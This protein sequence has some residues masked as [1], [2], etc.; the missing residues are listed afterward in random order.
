MAHTTFVFF[1]PS[2]SV[3]VGDLSPEVNDEILRKTFQAFGTLSDARCMWD[4]TSGKS[5]GYGFLAFRDR[6][7]AEQAIATMNGEWLGSRAIRVNWA[8]QKNQQAGMPVA[9]GPGNANALG[10]GGGGGGGGPGAGGPGGPPPPPGMPQPPMGMPVPQSVPTEYATPGGTSYEIVVAQSSSTNTT[11]VDPL[12]TTIRNLHADSC[13]P[14]TH[15]AAS[16][17]A[18]SCR[19]ATRPTSFRSSKT[20]AT[21]LRFAC[22]P[23]A[24]S[25]S[26]SSTRTRTP[27]WPSP[28]STAR[29]S[30]AGRSGVL[31]AKTLDRPV[32][33]EV[34]VITADQVVQ[35]VRVLL[36]QAPLLLEALLL[37]LLLAAPQRRVEDPKNPHQKLWHV[38]S[39]PLS[40]LFVPEVNSHRDLLFHRTDANQYANGDPALIQSKCI[41]SVEMC[42]TA[43]ER[44]LL[45]LSAWLISSGYA[46]YYMEQQAQFLAGQQQQK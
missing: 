30:T 9:P 40:A 42:S 35:A 4:M 21:S 12:P 34:V 2:F 3:F 15:T 17:S 11:C 14:R 46:Q 33:V 27:R 37:L 29:P 5:R 16:T 25:P 23:T 44:Q 19:S 20:L 36:L 24:A 39:S 8:N 13:P 7:D 1:L 45:T 6:T 28:T 32:L 10:M 26:S 43:A 41:H 31:G 38:R 22:R 18:T